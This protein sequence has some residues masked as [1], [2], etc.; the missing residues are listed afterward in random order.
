MITAEHP[1][2]GLTEYRPVSG[3][4]LA[5]LF[6]GLASIAAIFHPLLWSVPMIGVVVSLV[7]LRQIKRSEVALWGASGAHG[8]R[9]IAAVWDCRPDADHQPRLL[10]VGAG[11]TPGKHVS[12]PH[13]VKEDDRRLRPHAAIAREEA[14]QAGP[15][16]RRGGAAGTESQR[17]VFASTEPVKTLLALGS[18]AKIDHLST[19]VVSGPGVWQA[20]SVLYEVHP[21]DEHSLNPLQVVIYV[22]QTFDDASAERWW[23]VN[24]TTPPPP[25]LS[26]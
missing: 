18:T 26:M 17:E 23:I 1:E 7:A 2:P 24:V 19:S 6:V 5:A 8:T 3:W 25:R 11:G 12:R 22:E 9:L 4:S 15:R 16:L 10:A 20:V 14:A 13:S 21:P